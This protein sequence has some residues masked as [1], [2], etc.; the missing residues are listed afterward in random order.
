MRDRE[1]EEEEEDPRTRQNTSVS[2]IG[3][4]GTSKPTH[5]LNAKLEIKLKKGLKTK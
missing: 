2:T 4:A 1:E 5:P 3:M